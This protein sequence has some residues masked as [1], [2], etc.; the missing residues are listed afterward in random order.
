MVS[1]ASRAGNEDPRFARGAA[2]PPS[3]TSA[4]PS[5]TPKRD[6][7]QLL[8]DALESDAALLAIGGG[9]GALT[10]ASGRFES[11][12]DDR[13]RRDELSHAVAR[14]LD[15]DLTLRDARGAE[16]PLWIYNYDVAPA[17]AAPP[18][19]GGGAP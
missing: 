5:S 16:T 6:D 4:P 18:A 9:A 1:N 17:P 14:D 11:V 15:V 8:T 19:A 3:R 7:T 12:W 10:F 13:P 2:T